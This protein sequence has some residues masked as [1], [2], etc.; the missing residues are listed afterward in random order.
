MFPLIKL[1]GEVFI[2]ATFFAVRPASP[3]RRP[4][5]GPARR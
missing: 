2:L 5:S 1:L 3:P 4:P